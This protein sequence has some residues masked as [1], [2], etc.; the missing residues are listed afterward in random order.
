MN[1]WDKNL[2]IAVN[3]VVLKVPVEPAVWGLLSD[4]KAAS[5]ATHMYLF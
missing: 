3:L 4:K 5:E 2:Y 1:G